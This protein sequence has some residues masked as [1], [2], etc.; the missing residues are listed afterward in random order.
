MIFASV[1]S[2]GDPWINRHGAADETLKLM[3]GQR[4]RGRSLA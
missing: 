2:S 1:A 3:A 4:Y